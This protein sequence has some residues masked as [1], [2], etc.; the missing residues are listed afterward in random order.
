MN[1]N[2]KII[3]IIVIFIGLAIR[4]IRLD[5]P[6]TDFST[7]QVETA[8]IARNFYYHGFNL[9]T[10][11][12]DLLS[13]G[14]GGI[15]AL[16]PGL[17]PLLVALLYKLRGGVEEYLARLLSIFFW[18][19][20]IYIYYRWFSLFSKRLAFWGVVIFSFSPLSIILSRTVQPEMAMLFFSIIGLYYLTKHSLGRAR[21][22]L[23]LGAVS[24]AIAILLKPTALAIMFPFT[25][26]YFNREKRLGGA[27]WLVA[28]FIISPTLAWYGP[29]ILS[30]GF[31]PSS[32]IKNWTLVEFICP[33]QWVRAENWRSI[34]ANIW[35]ISLTPIGFFLFLLGLFL[36]KEKSTEFLFYYWLGGIAL[37]LFAF[38]Y[39]AQTHIYYWL[40]FTAVGVY[41]MAN[42]LEALNEG[43]IGNKIYKNIFAKIFLILIIGTMIFYYTYPAYRVPRVYAQVEKVAQVVKDLT[44]SGSLVIA[45]CSTGPY[46]LYYCQRRGWDFW[47]NKPKADA[48][49]DLEYLRKQGAEYFASANVGELKKNREFMDYIYKTYKAVWEEKGVGVIFLLK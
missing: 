39:H 6:L 5:Q 37:F 26:L 22:Y 20:G 47:V 42:G 18:A 29:T 27:F 14:K 17:I 12:M 7:R 30:S 49:K 31:Y 44:S 9:K 3:L 23:W 33:G 38:F 43:L 4:L 35:G 34:F 13:I 28:F 8:M 21:F 10:P 15:L 11:Q 16:E 19:G 24:A 40:P 46:F 2:K 1:R 45:S 36:K 32:I 48:I 41:F 25:F